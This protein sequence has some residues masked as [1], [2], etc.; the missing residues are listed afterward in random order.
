MRRGMHLKGV[1]GQSTLMPKELTM[2]HLLKRFGHGLLLAF[3]AVAVVIGTGAI[4]TPRAQA[5]MPTLSE[6]PNYELKWY[7][8]PQITPEWHQSLRA[9]SLYWSGM[10]GSQKALHDAYIHRGWSSDDATFPALAEAH[11][12]DFNDRDVATGSSYQTRLVMSFHYHRSE[13]E[14]FVLGT[15]N[16]ADR[17]AGSF[18]QSAIGVYRGFRTGYDSHL[19]ADTSD[20]TS[21]SE[22]AASSSLSVFF[23]DYHMLGRAD[24]VL[25]PSTIPCPENSQGCTTDGRTNM[26]SYNII[27]RVDDG[28]N[29]LWAARFPGGGFVRKSS[30]RTVRYN[31]T[32][33]ELSGTQVDPRTGYIYFKSAIDLDNNYWLDVRNVRDRHLNLFGQDGPIRDNVNGGAGQIQ[34][35]IWDP[36]TGDYTFSREIQPKNLLQ[37]S[38]YYLKASAWKNP[39][40]RALYNF[41][42][43]ANSD[44]Y[45][46]G[47]SADQCTDALYKNAVC[48][49][50]NDE[51]HGGYYRPMKGFSL[52][53]NGDIL[54]PIT[55]TTDF[56][57]NDF[58]T[59]SYNTHT[60]PGYTVTIVRISPLRDS[61]GNYET[62]DYSFRSIPG[63]MTARVM[64]P[65]SRAGNMKL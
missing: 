14:P 45:L 50:T 4:T 55:N 58:G 2:S 17:F 21:V 63:M 48:M 20:D 10:R 53:E 35:M 23:W 5:A 9:D 39:A 11:D 8:V 25:D 60:S 54:L 24:W 15:V 12:F 32:N 44:N 57:G 31:N 49:I 42:T 3:L 6:H 27:F 41:N 46:T 7:R 30:G 64:A 1:D 65:R 33:A 37:R 51:S 36:A 13:G 62:P 22:R 61:S 28:S 47:R 18:T 26:T 34:F 29:V 16:G 19:T 43:D 52:T 38:L 40:N 59:G 56:G